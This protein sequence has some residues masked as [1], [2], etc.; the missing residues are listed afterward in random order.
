MFKV[1]GGGHDQVSCVRVKMKQ[2]L[3]G[4][5][6]RGSCARLS[7]VFPVPFEQIC[8]ATS[9]H[10]AVQ[11]HCSQ[12]PKM[13]PPRNIATGTPVSALST[14]VNPPCFC[15]ESTGRVSCFTDDVMDC[16]C[17]HVLGRNDAN[18]VPLPRKEAGIA[19]EPAKD[20][21]HTFQETC[22]SCVDLSPTIC[23]LHVVWPCMFLRCGFRT[24]TI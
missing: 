3:L 6:G 20:I 23:L 11:T 14:P 12:G 1:E 2:P 8:A 22:S 10:Q 17:T 21:P 24:A 18:I 16:S 5:G 13:I 9:T 4:R 19:T 7:R 15:A